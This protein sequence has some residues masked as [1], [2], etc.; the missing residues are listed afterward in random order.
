MYW[1]A[2]KPYLEQKIGSYGGELRFSTATQ[3]ETEEGGRGDSTTGGSVLPAP[4]TSPAPTVILEEG[5]GL[6]IEW[7]NR[8][9]QSPEQVVQLIESNF[10]HKESGK[11]FSLAVS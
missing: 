7:T 4:L 8:D 11:H 1:A 2:P 9:R 6:V 3:R 5:R 10:V